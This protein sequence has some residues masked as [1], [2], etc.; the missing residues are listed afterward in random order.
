[1]ISNDNRAPNLRIIFAGTAEI[2]L[3]CLNA[4]IDSPHK[5]IAAYTQ[6]DRAA[7][8]GRKIHFSAVKKWA[9]EKNIPVYQPLNFKNDQAIEDFK[10]LAPDLLI[11]IAYG[12][13]LPSKILSIPKLG[14][15]NVHTSLLP[16]WRGAAPIQY[17]ILHGDQ[18]TGVTIMQMDKGMD[19]GPII[20][21]AKCG[22]AKDE[23][24]QSLHDKLSHLAPNILLKAV[25][26]LVYQKT[27]K[28]LQDNSKATYTKKI[29]KADALINWNEDALQ[30]ER[31]IRAFTPWPV[32]YTHIA[33]STLRI[34]KA[35]IAAPINKAPPGTIVK[36][37]KEG[38]LV[39]TKTD[40]ILIQEVQ[41]P[42]AKAMSVLA[43]LNNSRTPLKIN[44]IL[45]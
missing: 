31:K 21:Q 9:L 36:L 32:A 2:S 22:I 15:I 20:S 39:N 8:R 34:L 29:N 42:G 38:M 45:N 3:P 12:L 25:N 6:P 5:I 35:Q 40:A 44:S 18:E 14:A 28:I 1:M 30:I 17:A 33:N 26:D 41:F 16:K 4:L 13:I 7:G 27:Q 11:V 23:T 37:D 43:C 19:T 10:N 24:A